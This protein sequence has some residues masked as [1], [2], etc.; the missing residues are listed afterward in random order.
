MSYGQSEICN[1]DMKPIIEQSGDKTGVNRTLLVVKWVQ[2][3]KG[4]R[5]NKEGDTPSA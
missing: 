3:L 5:G 1:I 2:H 4:R